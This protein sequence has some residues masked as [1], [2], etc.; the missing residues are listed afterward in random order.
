KLSEL[1][2][3]RVA[4]PPPAEPGKVGRPDPEKPDA[5]PP[6]RETPPSSE[7]A[8]V[9]VRNWIEE[10]GDKDAGVRFN[11]A[12]KLGDSGYKPAWK[13]LSKVLAKDDDTFV[14]RVA[15]RSIGKL[16]AWKSVPALIEILG[17]SEYFVAVAAKQAL[18]K[19][20][21]RDFGYREN[22]SKT[23]RK[24]VVQKARDWWKK[25]ENDRAD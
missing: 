11:A 9:E 4:A 7:E 23:E 22:L 24:R 3:S 17:E 18:E 20:T 5:K 8:P 1:K 10:L 15:A 12:V 16:N 13:A 19:I 6:A 25:H 14:R 2:R 21:G